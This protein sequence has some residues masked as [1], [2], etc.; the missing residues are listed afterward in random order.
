MDSPAAERQD[1]ESHWA[2]LGSERS[3]FGAFASA[4]RR[5]LLSRAVHH[6]SELFFAAA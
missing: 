2:S 6:Y 5:V 4:V 3:L 1:W